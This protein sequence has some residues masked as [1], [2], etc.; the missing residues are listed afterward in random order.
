[1]A[2]AGKGGGIG[3]LAVGFRK[4]LRS[5]LDLHPRHSI[6]GSS[7]TG[8]VVSALALHLNRPDLRPQHVHRGYPPEQKKALAL[9]A[10]NYQMD[11]PQKVGDRR[12]VFGEVVTSSDDFADWRP[13]VV[14]RL[15]LV[16]PL[17]VFGMKGSPSQPSV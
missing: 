9:Y 15:V 10:V 11:G 12:M 2:W 3:V 13:R 8:D 1:V 6:H 17:V 4:N 14:E 16:Y 7:A 5:N